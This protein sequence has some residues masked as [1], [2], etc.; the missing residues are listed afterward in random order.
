MFSNLIVSA[1]LVT[2]MI[3][4]NAVVMEGHLLVNSAANQFEY[5]IHGDVAKVMYSMRGSV[6]Y[7]NYALVPAKLRGQGIGGQMMEEVLG[8]ALANDYKV[9]PICSYT[10]R[11]IE[12]HPKWKS[13]LPSDD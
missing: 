12:T 1:N 3:E 8:Y 7:L 10:V 4:S 6:V 13:L 11:Y 9:V 5:H 2:L